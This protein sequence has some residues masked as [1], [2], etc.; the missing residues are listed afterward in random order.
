VPISSPSRR[1]YGSNAPDPED[2]EPSAP[3]EQPA[4][5]GGKRALMLFRDTWFSGVSGII[6]DNCR[7]ALVSV[8]SLTFRSEET[9]SDKLD[10][11]SVCAVGVALFIVLGVLSDSLESESFFLADRNVD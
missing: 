2:P 5:G 6:D 3:L 8:S 11:A 1:R 7:S 10:N 4:L 9:P